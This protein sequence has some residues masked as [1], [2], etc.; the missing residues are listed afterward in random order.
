MKYAP[1]ATVGRCCSG[2][3]VLRPLP[4][5]PSNG[6]HTCSGRMK[7]CSSCG[8][9]FATGLSYWM[10]RVVA[11][12]ASMLFTCVSAAATAAVGPA[13][14]LTIVLPVQAASSAVSGLPSDHLPPGFRWNVQVRS[15]DDLVQ[16][17]AQS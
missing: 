8:S 1:P 14:Y 10:T 12:G 5:E 13:W 17:V 4:F 11:L 6:F 7:N 9:T 15:S 3:K 16:L 2:R